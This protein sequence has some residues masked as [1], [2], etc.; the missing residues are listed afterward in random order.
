MDANEIETP[1]RARESAALTKRAKPSEPKRPSFTREELEHCACQAIA[2]AQDREHGF[3]LLAF[4][5]T[6]APWRYGG[7]PVSAYIRREKRD[8]IE[9]LV[10]A[11]LLEQGSTDRQTPTAAEHS[12]AERLTRLRALP[13]EELHAAIREH[14]REPLPDHWASVLLAFELGV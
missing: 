3:S 7:R 6:D 12:T 1:K 2:F 10:Q 8:K 4:A 14:K 9:K 5:R 11:A 13:L